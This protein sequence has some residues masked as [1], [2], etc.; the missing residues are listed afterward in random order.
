M[1]I[2][3]G[4]FSCKNLAYVAVIHDDVCVRV[5][6]VLVAK[7][8][9]RV[10]KPTMTPH[11]LGEFVDTIAAKATPYGRDRRLMLDLDELL[12]LSLTAYLKACAE[13]VP[14][15]HA[16][17]RTAGA[18]KTGLLS[19][20]DWTLLVQDTVPAPSVEIIKAMYDEVLAGSS[21]GVITK[22]QF[23]E[24]VKTRGLLFPSVPREP[25]KMDAEE[26]T[27]G[28]EAAQYALLA[29]SY[30][31]AKDDLQ[32]RMEYVTDDTSRTILEDRLSYLETA[33]E[34]S[35]NLDSA[36]LSFRMVSSELMRDGFTRASLGTS[37]GI[38]IAIK[39]WVR[40]AR[41]AAAEKKAAKK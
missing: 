34:N 29:E 37:I 28:N 1:D 17:F 4:I 19:L 24:S 41:A 27:A 11:Q 40:R 20:K 33:V 18:S 6:K 35:I 25:P 16:A 7:V 32:R 36:W 3:S 2:L 23:V 26:E 21:T 5:A 30:H 39:R 22:E 12:Q 10:F 13:R 14:G 15:L 31:D 9:R 38:L 8:L